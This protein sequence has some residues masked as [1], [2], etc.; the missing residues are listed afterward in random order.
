MKYV[1]RLHHKVTGNSY[2]FE[3]WNG[4]YEDGRKKPKSIMAYSRR[5]G[6]KSCAVFPSI[7]S[8]CAVVRELDPNKWKSL[9]VPV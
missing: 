5:I 9:I 6:M 2:Y 8:A 1:I 3:K 4:T 7:A